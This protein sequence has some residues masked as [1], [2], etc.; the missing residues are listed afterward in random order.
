[1][2]FDIRIIFATGI[3]RPVTEA[4]KQLILTPFIA[5]RVKTLDHNPRR[6]GANRPGSEKRAIERRLN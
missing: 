2:P 1:M 3:H 5:Q 6:F 4:E